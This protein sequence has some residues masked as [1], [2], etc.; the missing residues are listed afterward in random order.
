MTQSTLPTQ[1]LIQAVETA[2]SPIALIQAVN[3]LG[4]CGD[5]VVIPTLIKILGFNN[6]GAAVAAVNALVSYGGAA[7]P[8]LLEQ[9]DSYNYGARA[10]AIRACAEI[11]DP[12][13]L[14]LLLK[15][16]LNDFALSVRRAAAKGLGKVQ[17]TAIA[18][19]QRRS[20]QQTTLK[21][22]Q[23]AA[24]DDEWVVRYAVVFSL[25]SLAIAEPSFNAD[26]IHFLQGRLIAD[27]EITVKARIQ[28][29]INKLQPHGPSPSAADSA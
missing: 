3:Q 27:Q 5:P 29:A 1:A 6:P 21:A 2:S 8:F 28:W 24:E 19:E 11:G 20:Q 4:Q 14:D 13:T 10:W 17:W 22:L 25:E 23:E 18:S 26:I 9:L 15:A 16:T 12:R 7:V